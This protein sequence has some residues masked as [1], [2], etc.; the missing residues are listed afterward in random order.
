M[1]DYK[2]R[3]APEILT[4]AEVRE[5]LSK[6]S[7]T[8]PTGIRDRALIVVLYRAGLRASEAL[9]LM[10]GNIDYEGGTIRVLH[11]KN[12][13]TR[14]VAV[15]DGTLAEIRV[16]EAERARL[17][18]NGRQRLF[19]TLKG[20][21]LSDRQVR[22]MFA[23]RAARTSITKRVHPHGLR[24]TYAVG[25]SREGMSLHTIKDQLGHDYMATTEIYL[26]GLGAGEAVEEARKRKPWS[27]E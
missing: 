19:C 9:D 3:R 2:N 21:P 25:M 23:R 24:H 18:F 27:P 16:W 4:E 11:G 6:C 15:D 17:G 1:S 26:R 10:P 22:A 14:S 5:L 20:T 7:R 13:K 8:A 12:D